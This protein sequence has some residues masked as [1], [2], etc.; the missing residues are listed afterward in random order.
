MLRGVAETYA[1]DPGK[2]GRNVKALGD[3][4]T[5]LS[6]GNPGEAVTVGALNAVADRLVREVDPFLGGINGAPKFPQPGIFDLL[7]RA[8]LRTGRTDLRD[9]VTTTLTHMANGGIYD[10]L[11]GGFAR[12][13]TDEQWLVPHFEKMLYDNAQ[14]VA[15]MTQVWQGTRDPLLEVRVRETVGWLLNE[16]KVPG[17][18]FGATLDADSEGEEGRYYVWTK[19]EVDRLLGDDAALFCAHYDVTELGNWEGHTILNRRTPLAPGSAEEN[20]LAHARARLLKAR[21]L[22]IRPGWD[23]KVLA[24]WNGLMIAALARA[25]FVFEQPGWIEAAIDAYRHVVTSLGHTGPDGLDR[26]YHSGRGGRARH[27]GLL[28]DYA[29]MGKAALTLH[30]I[31][32]DVAFLDQAVR[33]TNTLDRH[34]WDEA[35]GGYYTTADDVGDLLV[36]PRNAH[37]NAV[38]AGNGTQLGNLTRLW[39]LTGQDRYRA[40]AD[41]AMSAFS[42]ELGRNFFPLS[43]F[44]NMAEML[45]NGVHVVL[46]GEGDDLELF[47]AVLRNRSRPTLVVSRLAPEQNLPEPHPAAGMAM[48]NGQATA[49]VCQEMRC[50]L[51][52]TT[53]EALA[54]LLAASASGP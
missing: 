35:D 20:R 18:A 14:L 33:W 31:T 37:D 13:S 2:I 42:G 41:T 48:V 7:W 43:T 21:A 45:L 50:S 34:F 44:L 6:Q 17:G 53:P 47:N 28:E 12:Y 8:H 23:D 32:G 24:D 29:N 1:Q 10:H 9:A 52:V 49:Y 36:R 15:L 25:G 40:R 16:M 5:R 19:A 11:A 38:P 51:P 26:L 39:L 30:E 46:L 4:L 22:R 3:A 27:A 54:D